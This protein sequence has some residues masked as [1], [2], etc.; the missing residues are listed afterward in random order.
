MRH[1]TTASQYWTS[2]YVMITLCSVLLSIQ[3]TLHGKVHTRNV[4]DKN[5]D[6]TKSSKWKNAQ[7]WDIHVVSQWVEKWKT[8]IN[9]MKNV[10]LSNFDSSDIEAYAWEYNK[11][12][13]KFHLSMSRYF[14]I[15]IQSLPSLSNYKTPL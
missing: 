8:Q 4:S 2:W 7:A 5:A 12:R 13:K 15:R 1:V 10:Y 14:K 9:R 11:E 3:I 6:D